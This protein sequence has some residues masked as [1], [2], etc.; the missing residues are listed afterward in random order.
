MSESSDGLDVHL[1]LGE[2]DSIDV[3]G[4]TVEVGC[5]LAPHPV[6][7]EGRE[8]AVVYVE[9]GGR[10]TLQR[11][12]STL[13]LNGHG[14]R[15][16]VQH[17]GLG[18]IVQSKAIAAPGVAAFATATWA[19][20]A[21]FSQNTPADTRRVAAV[22]AGL[23]LVMASAL[24]LRAA[25]MASNL[26][27]LRRSR[28]SLY[29]DGRRSAPNSEDRGKWGIRLLGLDSTLDE[30]DLASATPLGYA[31]VGALLIAMAT[32]VLLPSVTAVGSF[33]L[34]SGD[35]GHPPE[36]NGQDVRDN[37]GPNTA[38]PCLPEASEP[39][40]ACT[41]TGADASCAVCQGGVQR[42]VD[43][44][45]LGGAASVLGVLNTAAS[46]AAT[47][48][49]AAEEVLR[50]LANQVGIP[51]LK[52][53]VDHAADQALDKVFGDDATAGGELDWQV[54]F[55]LILQE[56]VLAAPGLNELSMQV[57]ITTPTEVTVELGEGTVEELVEAVL[58][59]RQSDSDIQELAGL[60]AEVLAES[61]RDP[62]LP[63][64]NAGNNTV[65]VQPGD[66]LWRIAET[67]LGVRPTA[68][69][70]DD[71]WQNIY[72]SNRQVIG[73]DPDFIQP[74]VRLELPG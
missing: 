34:V 4:R 12:E 20:W 9:P 53:A 43:V 44:Q 41:P 15:P 68:T 58:L 45:L 2:V 51:L 54:A 50:N 56:Q 18:S 25:S 7:S 46:S 31:A 30:R 38:A 65:V 21:S 70:I 11:G 62:V 13:V 5:S 24:W 3:G 36:I 73:L 14:P 28:A 71:Y 48:K 6:V 64:L 16:E 17:A 60:V 49:T 22:L 23:F 57:R 27:S 8:S 61:G 26:R 52:K 39:H 63:A 55:T 66:S 74:E 59:L 47:T 42:S 32:L 29:A 40:G 33:P 37:G 10:R 72:S 19:I 67:A 69:E 1:W 35:G